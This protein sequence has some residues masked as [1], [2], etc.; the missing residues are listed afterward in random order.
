M[1]HGSK[2]CRYL[3]KEP[4][5]SVLNGSPSCTFCSFS[6]SLLSVSEMASVEPDQGKP[7]GDGATG[8]K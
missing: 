6:A 7:D 5:A 4:F 8:V 2:P 1:N 3:A